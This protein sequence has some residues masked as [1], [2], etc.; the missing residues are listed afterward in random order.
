MHERPGPQY[1]R[2]NDP[3]TEVCILKNA[4]QKKWYLRSWNIFFFILRRR[5]E[6]PVVFSGVSRGGAGESG[7]SLVL[8]QKEARRSEKNFFLRPGP[9]FISESGWPNPTTPPSPHLKVCIRH[10]S[11]WVGRR[12]RGS[13]WIVSNLGRWSLQLELANIPFL[14]P[15]KCTPFGRSFS[16]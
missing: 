8:D 16:V 5:A 4:T 7:A 9:P 11:Y 13:V 14:K 10:W 6:S 1:N 12:N 3:T 15:K 2:G